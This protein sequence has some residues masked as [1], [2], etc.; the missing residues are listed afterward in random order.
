MQAYKYWLR[1]HSCED[2]FDSLLEWI[3]IRVQIME[4]AHEETKGIG[5]KEE[6]GANFKKR[7][8]G[9]ATSSATRSCIVPNCKEDHPPW[10]C[11]AFKDLPVIKR[12]ELIAKSG[13]CYRC[14]A[15]G[16][17]SKDCTRSRPCGVGGCPS[18]E[19]SSYLHLANPKKRDSGEQLPPN[20]PTYVSPGQSAQNKDLPPSTTTENRTLPPTNQQLQERTHATTKVENVSLMVIP[21][22]I[23]NGRREIKVN[24]ML[25]P[26]STSSYVSEDA[27]HELGLHG[28]TL[29]LTIAGTGGI[30]IQKRSRRVE[31]NVTSLDRSF[32]APVQAHVLDNIAGDTP[33][34]Q[35]CEL[36]KK[37][38]HLQDVPFDPVSKRQQIDVMLG[39]DHPIFHHVLNEI[40]GSL[41]NDPIA[42]LTNLGWVC[43]G[44]TLVDEF[45]RE[46]RSHFTRTYRTQQVDRQPPPEDILR[47]FWDLEVLGIKD[48]GNQQAMTVD[49]RAATAAVAGTL[50]FEGGRYEVGIPWKHGEPDLSSNYDA[51]ILRLESQ[52]RSLRKKGT[53]IVET[54]GKILQEYEKKGY[55]AKVPTSI[56]KEQWFLPHFPVIKPSKH[57]TKVRIVFDAAMKHGGKS[58][59]DCILPG[60]KLQREIVDVLTR[61][62]RAPIALSADISE[63]FLQVGLQEKDRPYHRFLWR[64]VDPSRE[65]DV[66]EFRRLLFG[67]TASPFCAQYVVHAHAQA[68]A[69]TFPAAAESV[70]NAM[71]VDDL[72]DSSE[73]TETAHDLQQQLSDLLGMA[74]FRLRKWTSNEPSVV[75]SIP[76]ND[77]LMAV[78]INKE[79]PPRTKTLGVMWEPERDAFSFTVDPPDNSKPLTKRNVLSAIATVYDPLQFL[80]PFLVRA[81]ILMQEI[82]RAGLDWDESLP[83]DLAIKWKRWS[84]ELLQLPNVFI[85]R[86]LRLPKPQRKELHFFSDASKD[87][88]AAVS[89]LVCH[90]DD[91]SSSSRLVASKCRVAP[92]KVM[93]IPRLELMGA[94]LSTR[95]AQSLLRV[96]TV[97]RVVFWTDS[98]NVW[99]WVRNHSKQFK[100]FVANRI[101]EIQRTTSPEQW[102]HV[103]GKQNPADLATRGLSATEL[104]DSTLWLEGP[105]FLK[106]DESAW[107]STPSRP[108]TVSDHCETRVTQTHLGNVT[109]VSLEIDPN[110]F[111]SFHRL[112]RV[113]AWI[114]RY[115]AN[116]KR[117]SNETRQRGRVL[118]PAEILHSEQFWIKQAQKD[119]FPQGA[120][121]GCLLRLNPKNDSN[122]LL[123]MDGR[124]KH[125]DE[126]SYDSRHPIFL[127][128]EHVVT[129]LIVMEAH[130]QLGHGTGVEQVLTQLRS[131]FWVVKGRRVVRN[132]VESC[133][134]CRRRFSNKTAQQ[135][136]A[137]LPQPR[138]QSMRAFERVGVDYGGPYL[139]KQGRGKSRSKRYLCLFTCLATRAVHLEM[140]Y[141]LDT[142]S[143]INAFT[144][145]VSRRG[146]P[147]YVISD[148][149]TN[150]VGAER[151]LRELIQALDQDQITQQ[152]TKYHPI[153]WKFNPPSAPHFGGVFEAM[154]K[155]AKKAI[156]IVLGNADITDEE[157]Q[158]AI[159]GAEKLLNSRPITYVSS[160]VNDPVPLTPNHLI[161]GQ[162]GGVFAPEALDHDEVYN[163][164]NRWHRV[165]QLL[166]SFWKRWRKE[167]LPRINVTKKWFHP[168]H[169]LKSGDVVLIAETQANRGEWPLARVI[170]AYPGS[171]GLVRAVKVKSKN[172]EYIRPV[173]RL[174]P[175]EYVD[176]GEDN[177]Q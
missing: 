73:T 135:K 169:N 113:T 119:G 51:A 150:F 55:I 99:Y 152:T 34:I 109:N 118:L 12:K 20:T 171:D 69:D 78:E 162:L 75:A 11:K 100:P 44:P 38:P 131:R 164:R 161:I 103:P 33:A 74:G 138:F 137:P 155:S 136:M 60:P 25:D 31:L 129:R 121:T 163:P 10:I 117:R 87:A 5:K 63:M 89:F 175:L 85:P 122:G 4:E 168:R 64:D 66:Y 79:E 133:V 52:E 105:P 88:Y 41:P 83:D 148:N 77:R 72:L 114:R 58:L 166:Q 97:G 2:N 177:E 1:D 35:W 67:N 84:T 54:Y 24:V 96:L 92:A 22:L 134:E 110:N 30:E 53:D 48:T 111:S 159:C 9:Y 32:T 141:S 101:A 8:R 167:F 62:R 170:E 16:H 125:A 37:W 23:G 47:K 151:E 49:E 149:G 29:N 81:K 172:K 95:L 139:T 106:G 140:A 144:R 147:V 127:P 142:S 145:M 13:R 3:E 7:Q 126:L 120:R 6:R 108:T 76:E 116:C 42:R 91:G 14:L 80:A 28:Q 59:N 68:H 57:T 36:R 56:A 124:L 158:T 104:A 98:E 50:K 40:H 115:M 132:V 156:K 154:I 82:W 107:P 17:R 27:A 165:Q 130:K 61:F 157:L 21:A 71:Y 39:S 173:H 143:F 43:F 45:R 70:D 112:C 123:R 128:K 18:R 46:S 102:R 86:C 94:I 174:C 65:P 153:D 26:C 160:D 19:H 15:A 93:T 176:E 90:Y 146:T